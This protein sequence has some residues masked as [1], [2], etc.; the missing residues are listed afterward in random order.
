MYDEKVAEIAPLTKEGGG[1]Q[2]HFSNG[3]IDRV[4]L[5]K[6]IPLDNDNDDDG[7]VGLAALMRW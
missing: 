2:S 7:G 1:V 3:Q 5:K 6:W 4:L